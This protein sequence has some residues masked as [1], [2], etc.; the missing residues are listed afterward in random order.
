MRTLRDWGRR[1]LFPPLPV[2]A[3]T[4]ALSAALLIHVFSAGR[5]HSA[6]ACAAYA[7]SFYALVIVCAGVPGL[8]RLVSRMRRNAH[9]SRFLGDYAFRTHL[10]L[11]LGLLLNLGFAAFK[12]IAG[13]LYTSYWLIALGIYY[14]VLAVMRF[15]LLRRLGALAS[16]ACGMLAQYRT[17]RLTGAM[18]LALNLVMTAII[19]Q[20]ERDNR[21]Y[22]YP[23]SMIYAFGAYAFYKIIMAAVNLIRR[24]RQNEPLFEAVRLMSLAVAMMSVF[25]LQ[26]ALLS[27]SARTSRSSACWPTRLP[28]RCSARASCSS[29]S[30][31]SSAARAPSAACARIPRSPCAQHLQR[32]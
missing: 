12:L 25:S 17:Y 21:A 20:V 18:M 7:L 23:G 16:C 11:G 22:S 15:L 27:T 30:R 10:L 2:V 28:A 6:I 3:L 26:T 19:F 32:A 31:W 8:L 5:E 24:R 29:R 4:A 9:V 13:V 1:M 14:A